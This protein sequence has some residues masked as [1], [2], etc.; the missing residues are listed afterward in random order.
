MNFIE[1][2]DN[3]LSQKE[4]DILINIFET[5]SQIRGRT[6]LGYEPDEKNCLQ[7]L[8]TTFSDDTQMSSII[9]NSIT[10]YIDEYSNKY[11]AVDKCIYWW[12]VDDGYNVQKYET[13]DDG[14]KQWHC[15]HTKGSCD[16][17]LAWMFYLNNAQS[18]TEFMYYPNIGAKMGR[19]VIWPSGWT[20]LHRG[21][22]NKGL[23]YIVTGW[24][25][26]T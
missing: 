14:Y 11:E 1:I 20:H 18:G 9:C 2:Y 10:K 15:E 16:R 19:L 26:Y 21:A 12:R 5:S 25:S 22:P 24:A 23:K 4:C 3:A 6:T 13:E 17:V 8:N 7:L